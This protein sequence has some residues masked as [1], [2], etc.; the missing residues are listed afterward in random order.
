MRR[1]GREGGPDTTAG[2]CALARVRSASL[3]PT[4]FPRPRP[5]GANTFRA[6]AEQFGQGRVELSEASGI[7][8]SNSPHSAQRNR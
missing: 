2:V 1:A 7:V 4:E 6:Q 3:M 8:S 5:I